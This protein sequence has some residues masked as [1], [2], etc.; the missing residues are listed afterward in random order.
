MF[1]IKERP[2]QKVVIFGTEYEVARPTLGEV[3][4]FQEKSAS[5]PAEKQLPL[6][7]DF[8]SK[9]GLPAEPVKKLDVDQFMELVAFV[10]GSKKN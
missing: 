5:T 9:L 8:L 2:K 4:E 6:M 7:V 3:E 10:S 1:E